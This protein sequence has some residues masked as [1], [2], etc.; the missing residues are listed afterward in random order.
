[1]STCHSYGAKMR[2][3]TLPRRRER[4][5]LATKVL[6]FSQVQSHSRTAMTRHSGPSTIAGGMSSV[7]DATVSI[8]LIELRFCRQ[9]LLKR[10]KAHLDR[11]LNRP[12]QKLMRSSSWAGN[13]AIATPVSGDIQLSVIDRLEVMRLDE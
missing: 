7:S 3:Y 11:T 4:G 5:A 10:V 9:M 6:T 8:I 2:K 13:I 1:M 12:R